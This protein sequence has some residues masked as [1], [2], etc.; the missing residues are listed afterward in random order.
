MNLSS[1]K[2]FLQ[3][4]LT[5]QNQN[6]IFSYVLCPQITTTHY[7]TAANPKRNV[8][9][10]THYAEGWRVQWSILVKSLTPTAGNIVVRQDSPDNK[11]KG[12][13]LLPD[14][15]AETP[16]KGRVVAVGRGKMLADGSYAQAEIREGTTVYFK[17][18]GS[19]EINVGG[20]KFM[21]MSMESVV[22]VSE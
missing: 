15:A 5:I 8:F 22:A 18:Y 1:L 4:T 20:E 12:G 10:G 13:I 7:R 6:S 2:K 3:L 11:S 9:A 14:S 16:F 17:E 19:S 21:V